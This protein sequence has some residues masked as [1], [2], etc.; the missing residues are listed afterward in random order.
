MMPI[1]LL[2]QNLSYDISQVSVPF[3]RVDA[4]YLAR[5]RKWVASDIARFMLFIG[6][7]SSIFDY[8]TFMLLWFVFCAISPEHQALFQAGWV[9]GGL[10]R[11]TRIVR[12][13]RTR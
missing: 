2:V 10:L 3:D 5:P 6:P 12:L 1:Q 9:L 4:E 7:I 11:H 8:T 13:V